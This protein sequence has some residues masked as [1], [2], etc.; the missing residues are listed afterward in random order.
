MS[1]RST[2]QKIRDAAQKAINACND[3]AYHLEFL[4]T[5]YHERYY[6][7]EENLPSVIIMQDEFQKVLTRF[8]DGL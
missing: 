1:V 5:L 2:R 3:I 6:Y 4:T 7:V 8:R